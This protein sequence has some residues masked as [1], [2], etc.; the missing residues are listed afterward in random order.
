MNFR[1]VWLLLLLPLFNTTNADEIRPAYLQFKESSP[2]IF[3]V[4]W[5]V[6]ARN[7]RKLGLEVQL[8][9]NCKNTTSPTAELINAS[10]IQRW[11]VHCKQGIIDGEILIK[12]LDKT[13]TDVLLHMEFISGI[14][15]TTQLT[16][17]NN[18]FKVEAEASTTQII[19][20]YTALGIEH[21]L[22][23][24]DHLLF[25]F[26]LLLIVRDWRVLLAT[27][28]AFTAAHS[29]TLAAATMGLIHVPQKPVEATIALS[30]LFLAMEWVHSKQGKIGAT[31]RF[32]W[33]IA[34]IFGLLH[35]FGFA[36]ALSEIGLPQHA[37]P[38]A[39]VFFNVGVELGQLFFISVVLL[40]SWLLHRLQHQKLLEAA[41]Y[42]TVY[43]IGS[44]AS[45][46]LIERISAF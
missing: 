10:Y 44:I 12:G 45:F 7:G 43:V 41:E 25:V 31:E 14:S 28:T 13:S 39:L 19:S 24:I 2:N 37:I 5:K 11:I 22:Q 32:P 21:I 18:S 1:I 29:I 30:I 9:A 33:L 38:L 8:P 42:V 23:G 15:Q 40:G 35:G 26:A 4:I 3:D 36:G 6:P 46:W 16:P 17:S 34:F 20:T 27:I